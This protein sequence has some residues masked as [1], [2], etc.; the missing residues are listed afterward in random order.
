ML[1]VSTSVV[2]LCSPPVRAAALEGYVRIC[3]AQYLLLAEKQKRL[4][5]DPNNRTS[6][7]SL[8]FLVLYNIVKKTI[9]QAKSS[10]VK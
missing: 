10:E 1:G 7:G 3:L 6:A 4:A 2:P 8:L 5:A 9:S